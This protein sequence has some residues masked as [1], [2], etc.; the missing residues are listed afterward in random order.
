M[1]PELSSFFPEDD[2]RGLKM[3]DT[4]QMIFSEDKGDVLQVRKQDNRYG[5]A[6]DSEIMLAVEQFADW[7]LKSGIGA[8]ELEQVRDIVRRERLEGEGR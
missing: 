6:K 8:A 7:Q 2:M 5:V 3:P 4:P 1:Q